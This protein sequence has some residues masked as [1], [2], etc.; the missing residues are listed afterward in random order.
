M[1]ISPFFRV[2]IVDLRSLVLM[3][4]ETVVKSVRK[5]GRLVV[6][7]EA[8]KRCGPVGEIIVRV[9][10]AAPDVITSLKSPFERLTGLNLPLSRHPELVPRPDVIVD[11]IK[12]MV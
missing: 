5:T 1:L 8:K 4:V 12:G 3:D 9:N 11:A 6:V 10:E 2:E 7:Y